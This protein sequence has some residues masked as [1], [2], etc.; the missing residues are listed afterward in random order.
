MGYKN[1]D[2]LNSLYASLSSGTRKPGVPLSPPTVPEPPSQVDVAFLLPFTEGR[3]FLT[4]Q[5]MYWRQLTHP[6][7]LA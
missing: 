7:G 2:I 4:T 6:S 1:G 3:I 5:P